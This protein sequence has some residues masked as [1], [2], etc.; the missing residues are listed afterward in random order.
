MTSAWARCRCSTGSPLSPSPGGVSRFETEQPPRQQ[1]C[2][3]S[4]T[5]SRLRRLPGC[6]RCPKSDIR[7]RL[8]VVTGTPLSFE[9]WCGIN[10]LPRAV[11]VFDQVKQLGRCTPKKSKKPA[12][13]P[14]R[15]RP[16]RSAALRHADGA[17]HHP[18]AFQTPMGAS[19]PKG[20]I[21]SPA[22]AVNPREV[23]L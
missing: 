4:V 6:P 8:L 20:R 9:V 11:L 3:A 21:S 23:A 19:S 18:S 22:L 7:Y 10:G 5:A 2:S 17:G 16:Q 15:A 13:R 1:W 14:C 12:R